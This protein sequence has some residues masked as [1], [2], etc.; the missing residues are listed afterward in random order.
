[1]R[2]RRN[3]PNTIRHEGLTSA[4][5]L[6]S[7][8][9]S[10]WVLVLLALA[11]ASLVF[12]VYSRSLGFQFILDD[13]RYTSDSRIQQSGHLWDYFANYVWAQFVGGPAS[14]YRP[15]FAI[16]LRLNY[17]L[18]I[19]SP[20]G[21]HFLS[22]IKH[23]SAGALL[24]FLTWKLLRDWAAALIAA[25]L[26]SL[27]PAQTESVSWVTVPDPLV[28]AALLASIFLYLRFAGFLAP[29]GAFSEK[30]PRKKSLPSPGPSPLWLVASAAAFFAA[31]LTKETAIIF[32]VIIFA[33]ALTAGSSENKESGSIS[34]ANFYA[35][36]RLA[37]L[38]IAPFLCATVLYFLL[39]LNAL[40]GE[41]SVATQHLPFRTLLLS[42]P[43]ILWFYFK[44][45]LWPVR[46]YAFADPIVIERFSVHSVLLPLFG[47]AC[48]VAVLAVLSVHCWRKAQRDSAPHEAAGVKISLITGILLL[49]LPLLLTLN[50]NGLNPGDFLH[51][52]YTYLPLAGMMLL[53][54]TG[55]HLAKKFRVVVLCLAALIVLTFVPLTYSQEAQ[56]QDDTTV[57]TTAHRLAPHNAPVARHL[58]DTSVNEALQLQ[59]EGRCDEAIPMF[60]QVIQDYPDD[61]YAW[62]GRGVCY[63]RSNNLPKAE[64]SLHRAAD[65]SHNAQVIQ[66]WQELRAAMGLP[67]S[68][69][70]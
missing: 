12:V 17:L 54:A 35:R 15:V 65:I 28:L 4:S 23:V 40:K 34:G 33:I 68:A 30:R 48:C 51:G 45:M 38:H 9:P 16:W 49:A 36:L 62:A 67:K 43:A 50:L 27:H 55:W 47:L 1:M 64:E 31:L 3:A 60:E 6:S 13:H 46:S 7:N 44:V 14:F 26:F 29:V 2:A 52:R 41:L 57:F 24:G 21:W 70:K 10:T 11:S 39:R 69:A 61:W 66:Q 8:L 59:E 22:I 32:P 53:L 18:S 19:L 42:W 58:A 37:S 63:F 20:W 25:I 56:W 5:P